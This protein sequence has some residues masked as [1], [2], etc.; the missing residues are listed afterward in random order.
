[1]GGGSHISEIKRTI[2]LIKKKNELTNLTES[3]KCVI[4]RVM[5]IIGEHFGKD[6]SFLGFK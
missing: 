6:P 5:N 1:M 4:T 3:P 2:E